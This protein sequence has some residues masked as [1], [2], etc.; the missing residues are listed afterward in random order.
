MTVSSLESIIA[1]IKALRALATSSNVH[2]AAAAAA[3]AEALLQNHRLDEAAL[4]AHG[5][6]TESAEQASEPLAWHKQHLSWWR[7]ALGGVLVKSHGCTGYVTTR[8]GRRCQ[9]IVGRPSDIATVRYLYAWLST[10]IARLCEAHGRGRGR[11]WRHSFCM[12]AVSVIGEAMSSAK[13]EA[14]Q[15]ATS[16]ALVA[17]DNRDREARALLQRLEPNLRQ[18]RGG[19]SRDRD[20]Y[21]RG[22]EAGRSIHLG[23]AIPG[24]SSAPMLGA[25][26]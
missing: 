7:V 25:G 16:T 18:A 12:G 10:E 6:P 22:Q 24:A 17:L 20:A 15:A 21:A 13:T 26:R 2:E 8:E 23:G 11:S 4:E 9:V 1:K 5:P 14:R 19:G 3:Q